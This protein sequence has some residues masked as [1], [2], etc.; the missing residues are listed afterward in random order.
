LLIFHLKHKKYLEQIRKN[1][2]EI[3]I[4]AEETIGDAIPTFKL[5][6]KYLVYFTGF[7]N[8]IVKEALSN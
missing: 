7:K 5:N 2:K 4:H 1:I 8:H 6:G 3:V